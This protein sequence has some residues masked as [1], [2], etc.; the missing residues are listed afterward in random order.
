[1]ISLCPVSVPTPETS[2]SLG[3]WRALCRSNLQ[4]KGKEGGAALQ[5]S[6]HTLE[7]EHV[8]A[9]RPPRSA[10]LTA[11]QLQCCGR[12]CRHKRVPMEYAGA[13]QPYSATAHSSLVPSSQAGCGLLA[14]A[15]N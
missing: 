4:G 11:S 12:A 7:H 15:S 2:V 13:L 1:M 5:T 14:Q 6:A 9:L 8:P 3:F 10:Q